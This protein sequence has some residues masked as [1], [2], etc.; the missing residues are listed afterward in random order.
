MPPSEGAGGELSDGGMGGVQE[1]PSLDEILADLRILRERGLVRIRHA[2]LPALTWVAARTAVV[3]PADS[4]PR[5]VEVMLRAAV[6]NLGVGDLSNAAAASF[7]LGQGQRDRPGQDRRRRAALV[8][9]VSVERF[10]KHHE[11]VVLE[12][13]AE[14][15]LKICDDTA[16]DPVPRAEEPTELAPQLTFAV[17]VGQA[18]FSIVIHTEP[19]ELLSG[20]D[21]IVVPQNVYFEM[22][23]HFKSSVA[24]AVGRAA[25]LRGGDGEITADVVRDELRDWTHRYGRP[26]LPVAPGTVIVTSA[27]SMAGRGVRRLYHVAITTPR[28]GT[29]NYYVDPTVVAQAGQNV[30]AIARRERAE[31][32]PPLRSIVFPLLGAGRGGLSPATSFT[33][34]WSALE[35]DL[36][37]D[38][39]WD[40]HFVTRSRATTDV[41]AAGLSG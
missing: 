6:D 39:S 21:I 12:Q 15:I 2:D 18:Q 31:F 10:R 1:R 26:G 11:R 36:R 9:S 13:V 5:A 24:A 37:E 17:A 23:Q 22:P 33:W 8:Y 29:N 38:G 40:I 16:T 41:I 30:L 32:D 7:G 14:E 20:V 25:A 19:V 28:P 3:S 27:G 34:L 35:R 4:G